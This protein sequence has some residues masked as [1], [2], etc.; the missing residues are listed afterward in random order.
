MATPDPKLKITS[1]HSGIE[2]KVY[3]E[4]GNR[5]RAMITKAFD[6]LNGTVVG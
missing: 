4:I 6:I 2:Q 5:W 3:F 1:V